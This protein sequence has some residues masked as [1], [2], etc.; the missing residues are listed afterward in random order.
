M[1]REQYF[2]MQ[3]WFT[4]TVLLGLGFLGMEIIEFVQ[5]V[6][7]GLG[8]TTSSFSSGFYTLVGFHGA[9]VLFAPTAEA[10]TP[11][12]LRT[13]VHVSGLSETMEGAS[14]RGHF[15]GVATIVTK[16]LS[17]VRPDRAYFGEKD[18][19]Q[20]VVVRRMTAE[21][22]MAT[23]IVAGPTVRDPDGL[24]L[25]SRNAYLSAAE[26]QQALALSQALL[27]ARA[28]WDGDGDAARTLLRHR[29]SAAPG[30]RL[31]YA[32]VCDPETLEPL[33]GVV[34]GPAQ[35]L[36]AARVGATRLIDNIRLEPL[37]GA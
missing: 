3:A 1:Q 4:A 10:L 26:R 17:V 25:S 37:S 15:D 30:V 29:L 16:L 7:E 18:Y 11:P 21:L 24:A 22:D 19:Q 20:L 6:G 9:H 8:Y 12:T 31:D 14:R 5:Y 27:A 23:E 28:T 13:A 33:E 2:K 34:E 35:A 32:E 36:V